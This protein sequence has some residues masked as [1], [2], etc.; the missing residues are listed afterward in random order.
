VKRISGAA[1][2][3]LAW[4]ERRRAFDRWREAAMGG[5]ERGRRKARVV[6]G[7]MYSR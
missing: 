6:I 5:G 4:A 7:K 3:T 2:E 1:E